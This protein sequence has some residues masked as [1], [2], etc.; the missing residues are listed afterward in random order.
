M[1]SLFSQDNILFYF[2]RLSNRVIRINIWSLET[3]ASLNNRKRKSNKQREEELQQICHLGTV[4]RET[5]QG[6]W[7]KREIAFNSYNP[8]LSTVYFMHDMYCFE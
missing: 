8:V 4:N 1:T 5:I 2:S 6:R 7:G 3:E